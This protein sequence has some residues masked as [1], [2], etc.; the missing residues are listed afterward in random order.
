M[1]PIEIKVPFPKYEGME[2][3]NV[4]AD[5]ENGYSVV[6]YGEKEP[7]FKKGDILYAESLDKDGDDWII[8]FDYADESKTYHLAAYCNGYFEY[9]EGLDIGDKKYY[10]LSLAS[11]NIQSEFIDRLA[12]EGKKWNAEK[13]CIEDIEKDIL[14]PESVGIY[15]LKAQFMSDL[16]NGD[17]L[18]IGFNDTQVLGYADGKYRSDVRCPKYEYHDWYEKVQCKLTPCKREELKEG[19]TAVFIPKE[20]KD[21]FEKQPFNTTN[22]CKILDYQKYVYVIDDEGIETNFDNDAYFWYKVEPIQ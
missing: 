10:T 16:D 4:T 5:I 18:Y 21:L 17:R 2:V 9:G 6:E 7:E 20:M 19:D 14:V 13:L 11:P 3:K 8:L 12:K 15:R 22:Y 1:N